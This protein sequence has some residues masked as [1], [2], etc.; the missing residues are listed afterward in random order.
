MITAESTGDVSL[1]LLRELFAEPPFG[2][3]V[4]IDERQYFFKS[5]DAPSWVRFIL[6]LDTWQALLGAGASFAAASFASEAGKAAWKKAAKLP[7][8]LS[9]GSKFFLRFADKLSTLRG[10]APSLEVAV[11]VPISD[12]RYSA[13]LKLTGTTAEE[14]EIQLVTLALHAAALGELLARTDVRPVG[15]IALKLD[16]DGRLIAEWLDAVESD[17]RSEVLAVA[18]T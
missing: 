17:Y 11:G 7:A 15:W 1:D 4:E 14:I 13:L 10:T 2:Q 3:L 6:E 9:A 5:F 18:K 8:G 16:G 12:G